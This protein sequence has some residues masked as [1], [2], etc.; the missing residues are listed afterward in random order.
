MVFVGT[1][2]WVALF[3]IVRMISA[4]KNAYPFFLKTW[5]KIKYLFNT[6]GFDYYGKR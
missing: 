6:K 3:F 5:Y 1:T 4:A 2:R